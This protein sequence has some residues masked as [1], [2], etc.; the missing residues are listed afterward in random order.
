MN[1]NDQQTSAINQMIDFVDKKDPRKLFLLQGSAGTGKTTCVQEVTK[2]RRDLEFVMTAPTNKATKVLQEIGQREGVEGI[3]CRTIYSL[4][5][6]K[7]VKD[8]EIIRVEPLGES[9]VVNY[10]CVVVDEASMVNHQLMEFIYEAATSTHTKFLFMGDPLQLPPVGEDNSESFA[11]SDKATLTKVERHDNQILTFA[12]ALRDSILNGTNPE[13]RSDNDETGGVWT[14]DSRRMRKQLE[15]AYTSETYQA[16]QNS[17]KTVAWRNATVAS[18]NEVIRYA[19]YGDAAKA[20]FVREERVIATHPIPRFM[21]SE[22]EM[23]MITDEEG[24][25][26][27]LE[28]IQHPMFQDLK[29]YHLKVETEFG[30]T[31]ADCFVIHPDSLAEYNRM[32]GQLA[33]AARAKRQ[34]WSSFWGLKN[35]YVH[36]L[37]PC[38]SITAHR[39]QGSTYRSVFVDVI[40]I[41]SNSNRSEAL[42]CLYVAATR[43]SNNL[44]LRTR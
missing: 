23:A 42:R 18:Y 38:H 25:V 33:D 20:D 21:D 28:I 5:G 7:V 26:V 27:E 14:V 44:I 37:R 32:L 40:D 15:K 35:E 12:T 41:L 24:N 6:L 11:I 13:M 4:L 31:W 30:D 29:V 10:D 3:E 43:A 16:N 9:E 36:D 34:P 22:P 8:S 17:C 2:A 19:L 1:Y 39:S